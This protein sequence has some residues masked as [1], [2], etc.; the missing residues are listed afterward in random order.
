MRILLWGAA[1][2]GAAVMIATVWAALKV[3]SDSD[4]SLDDTPPST[5]DRDEKRTPM[6]RGPE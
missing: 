4:R 2:L 6:S 3:G 5:P 1:V